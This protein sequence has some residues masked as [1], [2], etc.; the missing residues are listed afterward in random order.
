MGRDQ[1]GRDTSTI[2]AIGLRQEIFDFGRI[3]AFQSFADAQVAT[4]RARLDATRLDVAYA[5]ENGYDAVLASKGIREAAEAAFRRAQVNLAMAT[6]GV[7][8]G[9]REPI[10]LT[11]A[12]ADLSRFDLARIRAHA[13]VI[14][15]Q[16]AFAAVV[17]VPDLMLDATG[18]TAD[19]GPV[20]TLDEAISM[21]LAR[22][23]VLRERRELLAVQRASTQMIAAELHPDLSL[24]ATLSRG[25]E[26]QPRRAGRRRPDGGW[27]PNVP[28]WDGGIVFSW[29]L[30]DFGVRAREDQSRS[31]QYARNAEFEETR[32]TVTAGVQQAYVDLVSAQ[33]TLP[34][35]EKQASAAQ[36]NYAQA[37]ARFK[38]ELGTSVELADAQALLTEAQVQLAIGRYQLARARAELARAIAETR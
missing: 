25:V 5:V 31:L 1:W 14:T 26:A 28:N 8:A 20:P 30:L 37:D 15:A 4:E 27:N 34:S 2:T 11:R 29:P 23:P 12:E 32:A 3:A 21:A 13:G 18:E 35:L 36:A 17:G 6:A 24:T 16:S 9:L 10:E 33:Q 19:A 7:K 22:D 38:A